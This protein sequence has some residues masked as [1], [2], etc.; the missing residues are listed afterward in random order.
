VLEHCAT[1]PR[2]LTI[3]GHAEHIN[4]S[5]LPSLIPTVNIVRLPRAC[6]LCH[7]D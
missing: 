7:P 6:Q 3:D 5:Y 1:T 2:L 4:S